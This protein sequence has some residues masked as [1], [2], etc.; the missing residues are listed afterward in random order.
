MF[1]YSHDEGG[2]SVTGGYV[3][4]DPDLPSLDGRYLYADYCL[5]DLHSFTADPDRK[6]TD[7]RSLGLNVPQL[8]SFG[9]DDRGRIYV[10][11]LEGP[12]YRLEPGR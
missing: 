8:S 3:V 11:S 6:A 7:D 9:E 2:C 1:E 10:V 5:G 12:V 4:R